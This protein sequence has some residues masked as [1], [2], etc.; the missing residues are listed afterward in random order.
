MFLL[1]ALFSRT[2][3]S[4]SVAS[5]TYSHLLSKQLSSRVSIHALDIDGCFGVSQDFYDDIAGYHKPAIEYM[6]E[7]AAQDGCEKQFVVSGSNRQDIHKDCWNALQNENGNAMPILNSVASALGASYE[8][9]LL[10]DIMSNRLAGY[11]AGIARNFA[12]QNFDVDLKFQSLNH[13]ELAAF[14]KRRF[15]RYDFST[16]KVNITYAHIH[17]AAIYFPQKQI[18]YRVYDDL[19]KVVLSPLAKFY[20]NYP[21]LIPENVIIHLINY[22]TNPIQSDPFGRFSIPELC[23]TI[24]GTGKTDAEYYQTVRDMG[25][26]ARM[27]EN[28]NRNAT[29]NMVEYLTPKLLEAEKINRSDSTK[30][31]IIEG[32]AQSI[33]YCPPLP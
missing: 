8:T 33:E 20:G 13:G 19:E 3:P 14:L 5:R 27:I 9:F 32:V 16:D 6:A 31:P 17:R 15:D 1:K 11:N 28:K 10:A 12:L 22:N 7:Q 23:Y 24:K 29:Y 18:I 26:I 25:G 21:S 2:V 4:Y 30:S